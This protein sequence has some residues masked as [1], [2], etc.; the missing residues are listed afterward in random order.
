MSNT[1]SNKVTNKDVA[2]LAGVSVATV[3][4]VVN[5]RTD[6]RISEETTKKVLHAINILC[7]SPNPHATAIKTNT[8]DIIIRFSK[9]NS[10]LQNAEVFAFLKEFTEVC[11]ARDYKVTLS[12]ETQPQRIHASAC[13]CIGLDNNEFHTL[14]NENFI[15]L[16][17]IDSLINDPV[18]YQVSNDY[19][20]IKG[21]AEQHFGNDYLYVTL[22]PNN[23][24]L[25]EELLST[26]SNS[27]LISNI[28]DLNNLPKGNIVVTDKILLELLKNEVKLN[29]CDRLSNKPSCVLDCIEKA[30]NREPV[31]DELHF[32]K[33]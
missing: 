29:L 14:A 4:Y 16:V 12:A 31:P 27:V 7:Y 10:A 1:K 20:S 13:V 2:A 23:T 32:I 25:K 19:K 21:I 22:C 30:I 26:I 8:R 33:I 6:K 5:G 3:S 11:V 28:S 17:A 9:N 18:F 15:P 24:P